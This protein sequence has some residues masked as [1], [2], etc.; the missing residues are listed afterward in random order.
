[1]DYR[2]LVTDRSEIRLLML[3]P[4]EENTTVRCSLEHVS[5]INPPEYCALSYCWGDPTITKE[6][7]INGNLV[8]VTTNL[9]SALRHLKLR[10]I[11]V[12][13]LMQF[14]LISKTR[15]KKVRS[16][17]GWGLFTGGP[18]RWRPGLGKKMKISLWFWNWSRPL[19][20]MDLLC[21]LDGHN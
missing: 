13:G 8:Q 17:C 21:L 1:M 3:L 7:I 18:E 19:R 15:S 6:V 2:P 14:V 16:C 9:E 20:N 11:L 10:N 4:Y 12:F 5:L